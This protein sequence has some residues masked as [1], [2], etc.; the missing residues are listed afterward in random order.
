MTFNLDLPV[1]EVY[2]IQGR[3]GRRFQAQLYQRFL[4]EQLIAEH[5]LS[6]LPWGHI[7]PVRILI[8]TSLADRAC[9][10]NPTTPVVDASKSIWLY[11]RVPISQ[12]P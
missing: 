5:G 2:H 12:L 8:T 1:Q 10:Y 6:P 9:D 3:E 7:E 4:S 11:G